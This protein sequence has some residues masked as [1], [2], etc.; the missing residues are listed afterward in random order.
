MD[1][2]QKRTQLKMENIELSTIK[3]LSLPINDIK[4][5]D[6]AKLAN[7]SQVTIYNYYGSKEALLKAAFLRLM[8]Q[9]Y[10]EYKKLLSSD[11]AFEEKIKEMLLRKKDGIDIVNLETFTSLIQKD[12]ELHAIVLDFSMNKSF[13][14]LLGLIDEGRTLGVIR[15]EFSPKTLQIY[16]Q[17]LSQAFMNM[18][19]TTSQYIQQKEVIDEIMNLFLYGMLKQES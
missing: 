2:Y 9:Q 3:L 7:V 14:L 13:K 1:G 19:A 5:M 17:V 12:E 4:I 11:I 6:I 16:I 10:E 8:D 15:N 18:D